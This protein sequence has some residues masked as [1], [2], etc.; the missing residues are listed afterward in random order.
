M[1]VENR[2]RMWISREDM[3]NKGGS[4]E[5]KEEVDNKERIWRIEGEVAKIRRR[6]LKKRI[7]ASIS[8]AQLFRRL[9]FIWQV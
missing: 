6:R 1:E 9:L 5:Q 7:C 8:N 2:T 4:G 3:K